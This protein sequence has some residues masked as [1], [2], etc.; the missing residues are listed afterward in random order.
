ME[1]TV[2]KNH[3]RV[4]ARAIPVFRAL[5]GVALALLA[6]ASLAGCDKATKHKPVKYNIY[7]GASMYDTS[8]AGSFWGWIYAYD[9]DSLDLVDSI[10]LN[11]IDPTGRSSFVDEMAVS[12]DG[13]WLYVLAASRR[14]EPSTL[15]KLDAGTK[16]AVWSRPGWDDTK[17]TLVRVL[18]N[19]ALLLVGDTVFQAED[20]RVVRTLPD[21]LLTMW[22]PVS[23]TKVAA[24]VRSRPQE[25][26]DSIISVIDVVTGEVSGRYVARLTSGVP[27]EHFY[28]ARLHPDGRRVLAVGV[29]RSDY[30]C[31]FVLGDLETGQTLFQYRLNYPFGDIALSADGLLAAVTD[32][33]VISISEY[34]RVYIV[35]LQT[36]S[37]TVP[38]PPAPLIHR[39]LAAQISFL[40]GDRRVATCPK[41][42]WDQN[43]GP[44]ST[45]DVT[46]MQFEKSVWL[47]NP[48]L[49]FTG[50]MGIGPRP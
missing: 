8:G 17:R 19:G 31:W 9:A 48:R 13:R 34:G 49:M 21:S 37:V 38:T 45:I 41:S 35:D 46:T 15:W 40:P 10:N 7:L 12:P 24:T 44:L 3:V 23:G 6:F 32:P 25:G 33:G 50:G 26:Y 36:L 4:V 27:L 39:N 28:T 20:G 30:Y 14:P 22:G 5:A 1:N 47:P 2:K 16:Q 43:W 11:L 42:S 18:Q 29:Y